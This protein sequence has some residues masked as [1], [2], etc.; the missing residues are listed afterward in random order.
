[1][2]ASMKANKSIVLSLGEELRNI[3]HNEENSLIKDRKYH[4]RNYKCCFVGSELVDWL[5]EKGEVEK[6]EE[7][8]DILQKLL[9]Y[10]VIHHG[11]TLEYMLEL[12]GKGLYSSVLTVPIFGVP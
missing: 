2:T 10:S 11:E 8:V 7:A 1:M 5:L 3:L 12:L 9:E 6:R 4:L